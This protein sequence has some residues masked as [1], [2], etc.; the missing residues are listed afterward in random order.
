MEDLLEYEKA[1][2][3]E[4]KNI[5]NH[6]KQLYLDKKIRFPLE[7]FDCSEMQKRLESWKHETDEPSE[8]TE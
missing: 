2:A 1:H 8:D 4:I 6:W 3:Q 5:E 7:P